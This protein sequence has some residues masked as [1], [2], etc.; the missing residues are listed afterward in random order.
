MDDSIPCSSLS[1]VHIWLN[2]ICRPHLGLLFPSIFRLAV[3]PCVCMVPL[4]LF[5]SYRVRVVRTSVWSVSSCRVFAK[6]ARAPISV[7]TLLMT[8]IDS[9]LR[10][11]LLVDL[12]KV[13]ASFVSCLACSLADVVRSRLRSRNA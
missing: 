8:G 9:G 11:Q 1:F 10:E 7:S 4:L 3:V 2:W 6:Y 13:L 12:V 5:P